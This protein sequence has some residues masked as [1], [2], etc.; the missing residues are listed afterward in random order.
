MIADKILSLLDKVKAKGENSWMACCPAHDDK[1][2]SLIITEKDDRVLLHCFS[3]QCDV[4]DIVHAVGLELSDLFPEQI[5]VEGGRLIR[6][7]RFPAAAI[8][9]ALAEEFVI[10]E[11]GLAALANGGTLNEKAK[12]RM[13][14]ASNRFTNARLAGGWL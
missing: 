11:L 12:A 9:E 7:K 6:K 8:L 13:K 10:A 5:R 3:H 4:S 2:P 1:N 14:A